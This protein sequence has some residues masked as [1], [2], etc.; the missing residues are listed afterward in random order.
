MLSFPG[1]A[2]V[3]KAIKQIQLSSDWPKAYLKSVRIRTCP[4]SYGLPM[5]G[6]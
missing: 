2:G 4:I 5:W 6:E 3:E 1:L